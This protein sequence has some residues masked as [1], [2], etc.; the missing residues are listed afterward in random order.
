M[1]LQQQIKR[2]GD[3]LAS[4]TQNVY[5]YWRP[6]M[7]PPFLVW[8]ESGEPSALHAGNRKCEQAI[9]GTIDA[10][11]QTEYDPL[12]DQ[13][14]AALNDLGAAWSLEAVQYESDTNLIHYTWSWEVAGIGEI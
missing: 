11:T 12:L 3:R 4:L 14:Q 2:I 5:H 10:Y 7:E 1:M 13:V 8:A 6:K 9:E